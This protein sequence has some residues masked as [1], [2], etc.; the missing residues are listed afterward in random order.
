M[1]NYEH[2]MTLKGEPKNKIMTQ[3]NIENQRLFFGCYNSVIV[4][5]IFFDGYVF[6]TAGLF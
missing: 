6:E 1:R 3:L 4:A 5:E 2:K